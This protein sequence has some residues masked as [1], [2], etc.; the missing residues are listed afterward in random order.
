MPATA[1]DIRVGNLMSIDPIVIEPD[2]PA[3][4]AER[5]IKAHHIAGLPV[6]EHGV[7][8]GVISQTDLVVARSSELISANWSRLRVRNI[9]AAPAVT[10]HVETSVRRAARLM[11]ERHIH[12]LVVV[13]GEHRAIGVITP[14]DIL[15]LLIED[16]API[17]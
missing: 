11:I 12:R 14:L 5:L 4:E 3:G 7:T 10:V 9:M 8:I 17:P 6:V 15:P 13:D 16:E 2:A 1:R